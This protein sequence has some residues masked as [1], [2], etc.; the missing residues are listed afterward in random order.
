MITVRFATGFSIQYNTANFVESWGQGGALIKTSEKGSLV[1]IAP[2][3][4]VI[5]WMTPCRTYSSI[6][7]DSD[8][9]Q[10]QVELLAKDIRRLQRKLASK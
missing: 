10:E 4:A 2:L 3:G 9:V 1:A 8:K 7:T 5:E 6:G